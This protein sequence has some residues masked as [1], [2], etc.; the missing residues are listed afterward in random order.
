L[1]AVAAAVLVAGFI[2]VRTPKV[3]TDPPVVAVAAFDNLS[4]DPS[5]DAFTDGLTEAVVEELTAAAQNR[6]AVV[7]N[8]PVLRT[9]RAQRNL[10]AI[11]QAVK[12]TSIILGDIQRDANGIELVAQLICLPDQRHVKDV[13][14][15]TAGNNLV[16]DQMELARRVREEFLPRLT[17]PPK[18]QAP[19]RPVPD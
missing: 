4:G 2:L 12:A 3:Q 18:Q 6:F 17:F 1:I 19:T 14:V 13:R 5:L 7:G 16:Q 15:R 9:P 8:A 11:Q 10:P